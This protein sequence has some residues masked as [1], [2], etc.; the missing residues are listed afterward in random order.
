M[1]LYEFIRI[2]KNYQ[3]FIWKVDCLKIKKSIFAFKDLVFRE[4]GIVRLYQLNANSTNVLNI[5]YST[6]MLSFVL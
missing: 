6:V 2:N 5:V 4:S 1:I 3:R